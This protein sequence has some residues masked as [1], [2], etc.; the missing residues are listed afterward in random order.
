MDGRQR[1]FIV[2][3]V[4]EG[5][6]F[7]LGKFAIQNDDPAR[8]LNIPKASLREQFHIHQGDL[9]S[10]SEIR[11][12]LERL[13]RLYDNKGYGAAKEEPDT[14]VDDARHLIDITVR[15]AEGPVSK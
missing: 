2:A 10:V 9:F 7:R 12:G 1:I 6:Q 15:I 14:A 13:K 4:T 8:P 3:T 5:N 11:A